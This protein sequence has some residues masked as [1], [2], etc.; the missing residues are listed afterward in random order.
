MHPC[1]YLL[2]LDWWFYNYC[3]YILPQLL[4]G[5]WHATDMQN[6]AG[7]TQTEKNTLMVC[8]TCELTLLLPK[9]TLKTRKVLVFAVKSD[10]WPL[11]SEP[12][13]TGGGPGPQIKIFSQTLWLHCLRKGLSQTNSGELT[14]S[15][16]STVW[17]TKEGKRHNAASN[18]FF[19]LKPLL[20]FSWR[21]AVLR[22][23]QLRGLQ[24]LLDLKGIRILKGCC[25]AEG[26]GTAI[27]NS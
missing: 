18:W 6:W 5:A 11:V 22:Q 27:N 4:S 10:H 15:W 8:N 2:P 25:A 7:N 13:R 20:F 23:S 19:F 9:L 24:S 12:R 17:G 3:Q 16:G 1:Q 21:C 26:R 14:G